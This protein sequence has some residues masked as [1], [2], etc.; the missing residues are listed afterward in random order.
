MKIWVKKNIEDKR[1]FF[2][3]TFNEKFSNVKKLYLGS[4]VLIKSYP[5]CMSSKK[6]LRSRKNN[7]KYKNKIETPISE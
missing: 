7:F 2:A 5:I 3:M 6:L 1:I 4:K